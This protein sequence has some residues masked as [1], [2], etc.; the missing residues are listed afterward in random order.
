MDVYENLTQDLDIVHSLPGNVKKIDQTPR[1]KI[2]FL[3]IFWTISASFATF[4]IY[5]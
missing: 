1:E 4:L 2:I 3:K 5:F